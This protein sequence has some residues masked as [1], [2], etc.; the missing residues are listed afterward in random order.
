MAEGRVVHLTVK[1]PVGKR[2][3]G[4]TELTVTLTET[5]A[6]DFLI[7]VRPKGKRLE[8][9]ESLWTLGEIVAARHAKFLAQQAGVN[10]PKA[11]GR[12]F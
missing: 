11:G 5:P 6:G 8:Y 7:G 9:T 10:V 4:Q 1:A 2:L 3:D 12:R